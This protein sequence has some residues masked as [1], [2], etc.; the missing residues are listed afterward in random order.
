MKTKIFALLFVLLFAA[1]IFGQIQSVK[2]VPKKVVYKRTTD[3][4][5]KQKLT[6]TYPRV[7]GL[8]NRRLAR[9]I[10]ENLSYEKAFDFNL[11]KDIDSELLVDDANF[12]V[13]YDKN[14]LL[15]VLLSIDYSAAHESHYE[16][17]VVINLKTGDTI[18]PEDVFI[19]STLTLLA[20]KADKALQS[21]MSETLKEV[22]KEDGEDSLNEVKAQFGEDR[23]FSVEDLAEFTVSDKGVTFLYRYYFSHISRNF[24]PEGKFFFSFAELKPFIRRDGLFGKFVK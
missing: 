16:K 14:Y 5:Y 15:N 12:E 22:E 20:E 21:E 3:V 19:K 13:I 4:E 10:E 2:I 6:I 8:K 24:E 18:K 17:S 9:K 7:S 11:K 23:S 1:E